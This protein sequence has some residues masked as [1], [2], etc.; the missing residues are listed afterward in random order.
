M[1]YLVFIFF[2]VCMIIFLSLSGKSSFVCS[3]K[4]HFF[5]KTVSKFSL[6]PCKV[7]CIVIFFSYFSFKIL[8]SAFFALFLSS[9][10]LYLAGTQK[11]S[12]KKKIF[13]P[14]KERECFPIS[15]PILGGRNSTKALQSGPFQISGDVVQT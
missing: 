1:E 11:V 2:L 6:L 15:F 12:L 9:F 8:L 3:N 13:L 7:S 10:Y 14:Q 4:R 5:T